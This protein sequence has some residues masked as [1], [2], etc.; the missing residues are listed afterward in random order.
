MAV[1][2][3][4]QVSGTR[5]EVRTAGRTRRLYTNGVLHSQYNPGQ[6]LTGSVWDLFLVSAFFHDPANVRRVLV[7]GV[8]GGAIIRQLEYFLD[9]QFIIGIDLNATHLQ[10]ARRHFNVRQSRQVRLVRA[11]AVKWLI[12]YRGAPFDLIIEDLFI[13]KDNDAVRAIDADTKWLKLLSGHLSRDGTLV[14]NFGCVEELLSAAFWTSKQIAGQFK[15]A[16]RLMT[17]QNENVVA[18]LLRSASTSRALR[19]H[20]SQR[21]ALNPAARSSRLN[22]RIRPLGLNK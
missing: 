9:P 12:D 6:P 13:D 1:V 21:P 22:Y 20:L 19:Q 8:G 5:Y 14:M 7:L 4:K 3:Q 15:S 17:P 11:D 10:V 2:W 16:F 18:A